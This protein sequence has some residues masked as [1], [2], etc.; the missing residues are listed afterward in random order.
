M[1]YTYGMDE[2]E[3]QTFTSLRPAAEFIGIAP[4]TLARMLRDGRLEGRLENGNWVEIRVPKDTTQIQRRKKGKHGSVTFAL[5]VDPRDEELA[6]LRVANE[7]LER[8][9][10]FLRAEME[11][12]RGDLQSLAERLI[13]QL[14]PPPALPAPSRPWYRWFW[15]WRSPEPASHPE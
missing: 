6:R 7:Y 1:P 4:D 13:T 15:S 8:E 2:S 11:S 5:E 10:V 3:Y 12:R 14:A 9:N